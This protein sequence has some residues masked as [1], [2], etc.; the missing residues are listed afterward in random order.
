MLSISVLIGLLTIF[1]CWT[2][3]SLAVPSVWVQFEERATR[4]L[5]SFI[6]TES[7][8]ALEGVLNNIG[9]AGAKVMG[10]GSGLVIASPSKTNPDCK[11]LYL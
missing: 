3:L 2:L 7:P 5:D 6:A 10:A 4:S 8:V 1:S 11:L 9:S